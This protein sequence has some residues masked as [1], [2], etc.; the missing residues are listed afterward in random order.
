MAPASPQGEGSKYP[1]PPP[2][3]MPAIA[4]EAFK[5]PTPTHDPFY[6]TWS[7]ESTKDSSFAWRPPGRGGEVPTKRTSAPTV[8]A[9]SSGGSTITQNK[10]LHNKLFLTNHKKTKVPLERS[11]LEHSNGVGKDAQLIRF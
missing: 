3:P 10:I 11:R 1:D 9:W 4:A 7:S 2:E 6:N 8:P 5:P